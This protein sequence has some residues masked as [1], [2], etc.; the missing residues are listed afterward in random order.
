[1]CIEITQE[2]PLETIIILYFSMSPD[3]L[4]MLDYVSELNIKRKK[5]AELFFF[6]FF[7]KYVLDEWLSESDCSNIWKRNLSGEQLHLF[8]LYRRIRSMSHKPGH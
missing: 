5:K 7:Y 3:G 1:M 4:F 6:F 2:C 8:L